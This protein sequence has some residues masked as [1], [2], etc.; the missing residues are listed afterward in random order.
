[1]CYVCLKPWP[2]PTPWKQVEVRWELP[3]RGDPR[4]KDAP[5]VSDEA[6][7]A[8]RAFLADWFY[9]EDY[10]ETPESIA[11]FEALA[12][13]IA[14]LPLDDQRIVAATRYV[15]PLFE[16]DD[17]RIEAV[18]YPGGAA[19]RFVE[20]H[21]WGADFDAYFTR[22]VDKLGRDWAT[23]QALVAREGAEARWMASNPPVF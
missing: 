10:F 20:N 14:A 19:V 1:M 13:F 23:W 17:G 16:D 7:T 22:F 18:I 9:D 2:C 3:R 6:A 21:G 4:M 5:S 15:A 12:D 11:W 8:A